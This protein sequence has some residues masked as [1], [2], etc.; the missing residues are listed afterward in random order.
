MFRIVF[1]LSSALLFGSVTF[2]QDNSGASSPLRPSYYACVK[3]SGGVTLTLNNCI[4][5]E[6]DFQDKRLNTAYQRLRAS[7]DVTE[8]TSLRDEERAWIAQRDSACRENEGGTA[9]L[10]DTNQCQLNQTAARAV[11]LENRLRQK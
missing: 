8:R 7:L 3:S 1:G 9:D 11:V 10:L 5:T 4:G 2:A 6:H